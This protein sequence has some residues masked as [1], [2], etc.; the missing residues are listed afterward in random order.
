MMDLIYIIN[1]KLSKCDNFELRWSLRS[2]EQ[3]AKGIDNIYIIGDVPEFVAEVAA[4]DDG[5]FAEGLV[6]AGG[7]AAEDAE[8]ESVGAVFGDKVHW[9][10]N[11]AL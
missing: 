10:N 7:A 6:H 2:I 9:V 1:K 4:G 3:F 8:T 5:I 11:V